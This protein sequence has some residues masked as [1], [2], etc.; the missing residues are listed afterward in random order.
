MTKPPHSSELVRA[1]QGIEQELQHLEELA[2]SVRK[3]RLHTDK[4]IAR[5]AKELEEALTQQETLA[6]ALG[7]FGEAITQMQAR[8][9]AA[10]DTLRT[11][12]I[13]IQ[14]R[15]VRMT[16]HMQSFANLGARTAEVA[17]VLQDS[18]D[19]GDGEPER[20]VEVVAK[21]VEAEKGLVALAD[22]AKALATIA[23]A[24][25]FSDIA[26]EADA[27]KQRVQATQNRLEALIRERAAGTS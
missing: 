12:A 20:S 23:E 1:A 11:R 25:D 10:V 2:R 24:E 16:E 18:S 6:Q 4:S 19:Q 17:R 22:E 8:Q 15:A 26:R 13:E 27:M 14:E 7:A 21:L 5:A 9:Q 3:M